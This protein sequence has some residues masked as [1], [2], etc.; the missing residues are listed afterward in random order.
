MKALAPLLAA[1][2]MLPALA[3][4]EEMWRWKDANGTLCYSNITESAPADATRVETRLIVEASRLPGAPD[5]AVDEG[6][7][8]PAK[9]ERPAP[10]AAPQPPQ[11]PRQ[12]YSEQR[13]RFDCFA[14]NILFAGGWLHPDDI[15][16]YGNCLPFLL[17]TEAWLNSARA[18]IGLREAGID[19]H[20]LIPMYF[21]QAPGT[22]VMPSAARVTNVSDR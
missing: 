7:V 8:M 18:E 14:S 17:G 13:R 10:K 2:I 16:N 5:P 19:W 4:G 11:R 22:P 3:Q 20:Q 9:E 6:G 12:I 21:G 15:A 1:L